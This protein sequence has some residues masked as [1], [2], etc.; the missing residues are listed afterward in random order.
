LTNFLKDRRRSSGR[1]K[2][3]GGRI[4]LSLDCEAFQQGRLRVDD[5]RPGPEL[6]ADRAWARETLKT[7]LSQLEGKPSHMQ[8]FELSMNG[9]EYEKITQETGL[10]EAA[11][12]TAVHRLR[13]KLRGLIRKQVSGPTSTEEEINTQI[14]ELSSLLR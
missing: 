7:C 4:P 1:R 8:A 2:R 10:R 13:R 12:K 9:M 6:S 5:A 14:H 11:A 3:G